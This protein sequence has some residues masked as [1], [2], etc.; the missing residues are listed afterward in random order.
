MPLSN[1][2]FFCKKKGS[3]N[4]VLPQKRTLQTIHEFQNNLEKFATTATL[5]TNQDPTLLTIT[6]VSRG[7]SKGVRDAVNGETNSFEELC[8]QQLQAQRH[9]THWFQR[10]ARDRHMLLPREMIT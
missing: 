2:S 9:Q 4:F 10:L 7:L 5:G 1:Y 6:L 3:P 8:F